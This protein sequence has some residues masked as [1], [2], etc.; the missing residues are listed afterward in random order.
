VVLGLR[1][2]S[3]GCVVD[4]LDGS[5]RL[6]G[7]VRH[8]EDLGADAF[9]HVDVPADTGTVRLIVRADARRLPD[10]GDRVGLTVRGAEAHVFDPG[11]GERLGD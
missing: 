9:V 2:D 3:L 4:A 11:S 6:R 1:P 7:E 5:P 8:L 10:P